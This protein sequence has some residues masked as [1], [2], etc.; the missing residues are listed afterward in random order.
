MIKEFRAEDCKIY[1]SNRD[2]SDTIKLE[3]IKANLEKYAGK[4]C[5]EVCGKN[6]SSIKECHFDHIH[7]FAKGG[8]SIYENCQ[9]LCTECN[10]KKND[11][12]LKDFI[13]EEKA[14]QFLNGG[15]LIEEPQLPVENDINVPRGEMNKEL[16]DVAIANFIH[17]KGNI[18]KIDFSREYN[19]LPSIYYVR[20]FYGDLNNLKR[21]FGIEDMSYNWNRESIKEA[22][23]GFVRQKGDICQKDLIKANKLPSLPC[24]LS[25]YPEYNNF[26]DIKM[27]LCNLD[28]PI[29]WTREIAIEYGKLFVE[30]NKKITQK[31]LR[32]ENKL[33]SAKVIERLFD[34]LANYQV[35]V[36]AEVSVRNEFITKEEIG[37]AVEEYFCGKKRVVESQKIFYETFKYSPSTISKRYGT[38]AAFCIEQGITV[39]VS[40][41]AKYSKR[42]VDDIISKWIKEG[43]DMPKSHDLSKLGLPSRDVILRYYEDW[44]EPFYIYAKLY[45]E[46]RRH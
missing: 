27:G 3:V 8:K 26:T 7:P 39:L 33:P 2:F 21:A 46:L 17:K 9:L 20:Q 11:K 6:L 42:E 32:A 44:R 19:K 5:C 38:F 15:I 12:E 35:I 24:I 37:K 28:I 23:S 43:H 34:S 4:I 31:D 14:K 10:L 22:L 41:R 25:Y 30:K 16:F 1:M 45:E 18:A 29:R 40:K 36:G 13:L